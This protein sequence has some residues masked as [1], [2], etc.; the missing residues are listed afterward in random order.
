MCFATAQIHRSARLS[1][2]FLPFLFQS[3]LLLQL[4]GSRLLTILGRIYLLDDPRFNSLCPGVDMPVSLAGENRKRTIRFF[5]DIAEGTEYLLKRLRA[6]HLMNVPGLFLLQT[7]HP[8][9]NGPFRQ[10]SDVFH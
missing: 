5:A 7:D 2:S 6:K 10:N 3:S 4:S 1:C 8:R 9:V